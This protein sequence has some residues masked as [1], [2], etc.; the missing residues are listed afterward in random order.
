MADLQVKKYDLFTAGF[1]HTR[2]YDNPYTA[3][4][5]TARFDKPDGTVVWLPLFWDGD[6][7][8]RLRLS[9]DQVGLWT[10]QI[11]SADRGLHGHSGTFDVVDSMLRGGIQVMDGQPRHFAYQNGQPFW[12]VGDTAWGLMTD[13]AGKKHHRQAAEAHLRRRAEQGFNVVHVMLIS[14]AGWG[15]N[16]GDAFFNLSAEIINPAYWRE[17]DERIAYANTKGITVGLVLAWGDKGRN[18]N[19]WREFPSQAARERYARYVVARYGALNVYFIVAGE[20]NAD[21]RIGQTV[22]EERAHAEYNALGRLISETDGHGRL[23]GIHPIRLAREFGAEPWCSFGDYQ[24]KYSNLHGEILK[25]FVHDKPVVNAEYAYYLR[26]Q[27]EDGVCDKQNSHNLE[28][29]RHATWDILMA[30]GYL[31]TGWG[32]TYFGGASQPQAL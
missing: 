27:D 16:G 31:I 22:S 32:N 26:D 17:V 13:N 2:V 29:I 19:D 24:Q 5:A 1:D 18:P 30:G 9:P 6:T 25:S 20:W 4:S 8:W 11:E 23:V 12:F 3:V 10:W 15:N 7:T 28:T 21:Y 14:E